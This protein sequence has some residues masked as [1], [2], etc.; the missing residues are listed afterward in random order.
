MPSL[1]RAIC[2][3]SVIADTICLRIA[4]SGKFTL[5]IMTMVSRRAIASRGLFACTVVM[6]A[7]V[8]GIHACN[9]S[10]ASSLRTSPTMMRF[11]RIR[12]Y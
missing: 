8:A 4:F 2:S 7:I 1:K 5:P 3:T 12:S 10:S 9:M 11:G 6:R